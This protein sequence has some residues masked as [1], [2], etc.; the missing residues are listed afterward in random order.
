MNIRF[1]NTTALFCAIASLATNMSAAGAFELKMPARAPRPK[2][3]ERITYTPDLL[4]VMPGKNLKDDDLKET[5]EDVHGT[6]I[7][8]MGEGDL[9]CYIVKT[10]K[11]HME[12]TEKK[13]TK[14]KKHFA[15]ISRNYRIPATVVPAAASNSQFSS[16]WHLQAL[17]CPDAWNT[18]T[19]S[20]VRIAVFDTG[21]AASNSDLAG[22]T[23]KGFDAYGAVGKIM[24]AVGLLPVFLQP[25][26]T[27]IAGAAA[28]VLAGRAD[29]DNGAG[30]HGTVVA[31]TIAATMNN[32]FAGV[33]V[34][35]NARIYPVRIAENK[36]PLD[37]DHEYTTDLEMIAGM[38][39]IMSKPDIRIVNISYNFPV[40]GFHNAMLHP[41][42][43]TYFQKFFYEPYHS[44][45]IFMSAGNE[46]FPDP[47][48][49][50]PYLCVISGVDR[51]GKLADREHWGSNYGPAV[52]FT[53]PAVE[54]GCSDKANM[55]Q[56]PDGTSFSC[57][58]VAAVAALILDKKPMAPNLEVLR[59]LIKSCKNI[60]G[61]PGFNTYYGWGMP[62]AY[63]A[64]TG[65][66]PHP[67]AAADSGSS[68][69]APLNA[70][71]GHAAR[72][73][74]GGSAVKVG[75]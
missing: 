21:C 16:Q 28:G 68:S 61:V 48:P 74:G 2:P 38:I 44:G 32:N 42:L 4:I 30:S 41:A 17:H 66:D 67:P 25:G 54:I 63:T 70:A 26:L 13:L 9:K 6:V 58:I 34:A 57:P 1:R 45:L 50:V 47:T 56:T 5:M 12:E 53:G 75:P 35:P 51:D 73:G 64:V 23:D 39:H 37:K 11:G 3:M 62:D 33:G 55:P 31:T 36:S 60:K 24:G 18:A 40:G 59:I 29:S 69:P 7:G 15:T 65:K 22:K 8:S 20:G 10:E 27:E 43:H 49:P 19:G 71:S 46:S 14:D 72:R 52:T